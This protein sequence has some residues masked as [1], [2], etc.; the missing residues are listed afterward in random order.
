MFMCMGVVGGHV[1]FVYVS[2]LRCLCRVVSFLFGCVSGVVRDVLVVK[3]SACLCADVSVSGCAF[4]CVFTGVRFDSVFKGVC[5][6]VCV[7]GCLCVSVFRGV[8][9]WLCS[10]VCVCVTAT[11]ETDNRDWSIRMH[12]LPAVFKCLPSYLQRSL[13]LVDPRGFCD[14]A[15][16][17]C[18]V[19]VT[20][21]LQCC[22]FPVFAFVKVIGSST[23]HLCSIRISG[24]ILPPGEG[25]WSIV[26]ET[27]QLCL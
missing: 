6:C 1:C 9:M 10:R 8:C 2:V 12:P 3:L 25:C 20:L 7:E 23:C 21:A 26:I 4:A 22:C 13:W 17:L 27:R 19:H 5:M 15:V 18:C 24:P 11:T 14:S 16:L